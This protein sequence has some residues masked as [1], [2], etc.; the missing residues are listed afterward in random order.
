MALDERWKTAPP[1]PRLVTSA[2]DP[3][4]TSPRTRGGAVGS[5]VLT[6]AADGGSSRLV[7]TRRA[8]S[9][10]AAGVS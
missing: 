7:A 6:G 8:W 4:L 10:P 2:T 5:A 3:R 9:T 1:D